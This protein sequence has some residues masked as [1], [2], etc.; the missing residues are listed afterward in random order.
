MIDLKQFEVSMTWTGRNKLNVNKWGQ[1][2][3]FEWQ[4]LIGKQRACP[5]PDGKKVNH[6]AVFNLTSNCSK[7]CI[8]FWHDSHTVR[9]SRCLF[10]RKHESSNQFQHGLTSMSWPSIP[11]VKINVMLTARPLVTLLDRDHKRKGCDSLAALSQNEE[12]R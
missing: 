6:Q 1:T 12:W 10:N 5:N 9:H 4:T 8:I 7:I 11:S 2:C 3:K